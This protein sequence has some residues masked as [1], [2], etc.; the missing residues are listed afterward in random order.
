MNLFNSN[1]LR[2][3]VVQQ[4]LMCSFA[5]IQPVSTVQRSRILGCLC[6]D[7]FFT[8]EHI[9]VH[10]LQTFQDTVWLHH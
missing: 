4:I 5:E 1:L 8:S 3:Y 10:L 2:E 9:S 7:N 6:K